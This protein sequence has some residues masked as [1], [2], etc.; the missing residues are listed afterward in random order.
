MN[1]A[2]VRCAL[3]M[4]LGILHV[5]CES[6][7]TPNFGQVRL[8]N[9]SLEPVQLLV[10][11]EKAFTVQPGNKNH[12]SVEE[13]IQQI[14]IQDLAGRQ[15]FQQNAD[16]P[17]NT[18]AEY[19][20]LPGG[21]V[22]AGAGNIQ[23]PDVVGGD[24]EQIRV[25]NQATYT[26]DLFANDIKLVSVSPLRAATVDVANVTLKISFRRQGGG[27]LFE[28]TIEIPRNTVIHYAVLPDGTV[29]ATGGAIDRNIQDEYEYNRYGNRN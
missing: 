1:I 17:D 21:D 20:V 23:R 16:I 12:T 14:V 27:V 29:V 7:S 11:G 9:D 4:S 8:I 18:F 13:G 3:L 24:R 22:V 19:T 2:L 25:E 6:D 5:G 10:S 28:Q 15:L 26:V